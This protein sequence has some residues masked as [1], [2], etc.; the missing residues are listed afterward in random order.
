MSIFAEWQRIREVKVLVLDYGG[1]FKDYDFNT[2]G[3]R[4][5]CRYCWKGRSVSQLLVVKIRDRGNLKN[6]TINVTVPKKE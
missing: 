3:Y 6:C 1:L 5:E 4:S 2:Q